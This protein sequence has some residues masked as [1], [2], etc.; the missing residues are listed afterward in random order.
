MPGHMLSASDARSPSSPSIFS[1]LLMS[2]LKPSKVEPH[3]PGHT[4]GK[5]HQDRAMLLFLIVSLFSEPYA[6]EVQIS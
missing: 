4:A 5:Q 6:R 3:A 2:S 1:I